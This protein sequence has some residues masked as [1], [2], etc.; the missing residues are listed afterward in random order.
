MYGFF[1]DV[2]EKE[3]GESHGTARMESMLEKNKYLHKE[4][5]Q[6]TTV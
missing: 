5:Q 1:D 3:R 4:T 2:D 6:I